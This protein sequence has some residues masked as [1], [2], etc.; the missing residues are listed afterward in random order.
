MDLRVAENAP[1]AALSCV[2]NVFIK[3]MHFTKAGDVEQGH[4]HCF[5]HVTLLASGRIRL[6]ALGA[7][8]DFTAPHH[9]FIKAGVVHE[10]EALED[11]TVVHCI[12]AIRDGGRVEDI[13]DPATLQKY[14][15]DPHNSDLQ[16]YP[17]T[18][19]A[20]DLLLTNVST[21]AA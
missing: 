17:Y 7:S 1:V 14:M 10:L 19:D 15:D 4:A 11:N 16:F 3:Q 5:D 20:R 9:I 18:E 13:I 8:T 2:S 6:T 21:S 12:H